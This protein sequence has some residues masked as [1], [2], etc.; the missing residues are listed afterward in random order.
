MDVQIIEDLTQVTAHIL[1]QIIIVQEVIMEILII[2]MVIVIGI[3]T[4]EVGDI[5]VTI[6]ND[7]S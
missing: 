7:G 4:M 5:I 1:T 2:N 6:I 3:M